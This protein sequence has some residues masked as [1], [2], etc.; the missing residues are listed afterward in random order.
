MILQQLYRLSETDRCGINGYRNTWRACKSA[1]EI[2]QKNWARII[3]LTKCLTAAKVASDREADERKWKEVPRPPRIPAA[4]EDFI[5]LVCSNDVGVFEQFI[6]SKAKAQLAGGN[7]DNFEDAK[8][9]LLAHFA[10][11]V[12]GDLH[13]KHPDKTDDEI[14]GILFDENFS[15]IVKGQRYNYANF[16]SADSWLTAAKDFQILAAQAQ[17]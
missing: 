5:R 9:S 17:A 16:P 12:T 2:V 11:N 3:R 1:F 13:T 10:N 8:K 15:G 14:A 6:A 4:H 7:A